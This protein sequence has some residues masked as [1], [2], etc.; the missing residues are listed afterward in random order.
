MS[1][2]NQAT[3]GNNPSEKPHRSAAMVRR[4]Y[5][6]CASWPWFGW[7]CTEFVDRWTALSTACNSTHCRLLFM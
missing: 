7:S 3:E 5:C 6:Y 1:Y 4:C 2:S